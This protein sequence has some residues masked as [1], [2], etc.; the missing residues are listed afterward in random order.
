MLLAFEC[1]A[2][3]L[4]W[5]CGGRASFGPAALTLTATGGSPA[6]RALGSA[7]ALACAAGECVVDKLPITPSRLA[8]GPL[9]GRI[10]SGAASAVVLARRNDRPVLLPAVCGAAGAAAGSFAGAAWRRRAAERVPDWQA[11]LV[12]DVATTALAW[13]AAAR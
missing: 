13:R 9:G 12:E 4:G 7:G 6:V 5:A 8:S 1:R 2:F 3:F 10:V 11:A